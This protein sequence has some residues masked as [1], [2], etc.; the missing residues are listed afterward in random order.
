MSRDASLTLDWADGTYA[1]RLGWSELEKLQ[2]ACDAGPYVILQRLTAG[3]W[4]VGDIAHSLRLGLIG[5]GM[6]PVAAL[7]KVREYVE[8][9]PPGENVLP[10]HAVLS[11]GCMGA[12]DEETRRDRPAASDSDRLDDL[13]DGKFRFATI[14]GAGAAMGFTPQQVGEMSVWQFMAALDGF[15]KANSSDDGKTLSA[16]EEES[17]WEAVK[18][19]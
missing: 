8:K 2:E 7:N 15:A 11:A 18:D 19:D 12:P 9:R 6:A 1:F 3:T 13:P 10:A 17:L 16:A 5:G 4:R 14:Y